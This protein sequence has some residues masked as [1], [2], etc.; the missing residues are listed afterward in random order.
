LDNW[1][2]GLIADWVDS[3]K[4]DEAEW[5]RERRDILLYPEGE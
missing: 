3:W 2:S 4:A 5:R 1:D